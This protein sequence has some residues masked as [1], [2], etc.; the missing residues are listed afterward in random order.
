M[1]ILSVLRAGRVYLFKEREDTERIAAGHPEQELP[2]IVFVNSNRLWFRAAAGP[3]KC[4]I[5][6]VRIGWED[7]EEPDQV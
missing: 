6:G 4:V 2:H 7:D 3:Q 5:G 1:I